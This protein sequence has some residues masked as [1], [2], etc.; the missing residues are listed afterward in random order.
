MAVAARAVPRY[1]TTSIAWEGSDDDPA[2]V[3]DDGDHRASEVVV[4]A[5]SRVQQ[6][7]VPVSNPKARPF[8]Q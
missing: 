4:A 2:H 7:N 6:C 5:R 1:R 8:E 3:I